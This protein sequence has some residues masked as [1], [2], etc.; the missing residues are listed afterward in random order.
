MSKFLHDDE[1]DAD[2]ADNDDRAKT[3]PEHFLRKQ[4]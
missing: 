1:N 3:I 4:G 2:A